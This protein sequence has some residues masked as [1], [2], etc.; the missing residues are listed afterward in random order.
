MLSDPVYSK[1]PK[2]QKRMYLN[3]LELEILSVANR[4]YENSELC[5]WD[6]VFSTC[7]ERKI[8]TGQL[9]DQALYHKNVNKSPIELT[10]EEVESGGLYDF[11]MRNSK[12][13][14]VAISSE[15]MTDIGLKYLPMIDFHCSVN[16]FNLSV[17]K[18]ICERLFESESYVLES[19]RSY[20]GCG[21]KLVSY[22]QWLKT[23]AKGLLFG[24][25]V[26]RA[27][28]AHQLI[29][30]KGCLRVSHGMNDKLPFV[31]DRVF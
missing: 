19:G 6:I 22:K 20:H 14:I 1:P 12:D 8:I 23:M 15:V 26:D 27:Y 9:L 2:L 17:A 10:R 29:E 28:I 13:H 5:F 7:L 4:K 18:S 24:G 16:D 3:N 21:V 30:G 31:V 11:V 25:I